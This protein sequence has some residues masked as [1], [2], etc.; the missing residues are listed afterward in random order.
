MR[1]LFFVNHFLPDIGGVQ[2]SVRMTAE[3]LGRR[4][5]HVTVITE[6]AGGGMDDRA[7]PFD[8]IRFHVRRRRPFTRLGYWRWMWRQRALLAAADV[9]HFHDYTTFF[10]WFLPLR[11]LIRGPRYAVTFHGFE[12]IPVRPR[13]RFFRA[14][15]AR[16]CHIRFGVGDYLRKLY[17]HPVD[18]VYLGAPVRSLTPRPTEPRSRLPEWTLVYAGRLA[19]DTGIVPLLAC[20][21]DAARAAGVKVRV[22]VAG[23]GPLREEASAL[24]AGPFS[25]EIHGSTEAIAEML[26]GADAMVATGFLGILEAWTSGLPVLVPAF[27]PLKQ[28]YVASIPEAG[29][30][31]TVLASAAQCA[32]VL[33]GM[34]RGG[35]DETLAVRAGRA[36][37]VVSQYRWDDIA[38][39]Y[40]SWY[41]ADGTDRPASQ[42]A[43]MDAERMKHAH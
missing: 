4:G 26:P 33:P 30:C 41:R 31:L 42:H 25:V 24:S 18:A 9:L 3:A 14:V 17:R 27:T 11:A 34:V 22:R 6:T 1:I 21:R 13:H 15:T 10:H 28:M 40:E 29:A 35:M 5:H 16:C 43:V 38:V 7:F 2:W 20:L 8:V 36:A 12:G 32:E 23:D 39:L 37:A 19:A